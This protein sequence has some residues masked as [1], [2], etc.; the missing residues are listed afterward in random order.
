MT[1]ESMRSETAAA[2]RTHENALAMVREEREYALSEQRALMETM[3]D[4]FALA[5]QA[6]VASARREAR[7]SRAALELW[8]HAGKRHAAMRT[9][10]R[11]L[12]LKRYFSVIL[13]LK[14]GA[15]KTYV[16][17]I[18]VRAGLA[19]RSRFRRR[20]LTTW[21]ATWSTRRAHL[22]H[23][24]LAVGAFRDSSLRISFTTWAAHTRDA[25]E[26]IR[27]RAAA[28]NE[29][30]GNSHRRAWVSWRGSFDRRRKMRAALTGLRFRQ[31]RL[32][33]NSLTLALAELT[34]HRRKMRSVISSIDPR[35]ASAKRVINTL[36]RA[37][38]LW[39]RTVNVTA[40]V[41]HRHKRQGLLEWYS[42]YLSASQQKSAMRSGIAAMR[43]TGLRR[44]YSTWQ[45]HVGEV[46]ARHQRM[47]LALAELHG[48]GLRK[49]WASLMDAFEIRRRAA[50]FLLRMKHG[51]LLRGYNTM[52]VWALQR[53]EDMT[54]LRGALAALDPTRRRMKHTWN[55][56]CA[57][58]ED[59]C[60]MRSAAFG[61]VHSCLRRG[62][63]AWSELGASSK[64]QMDALLRGTSA[65]RNRGMRK[66]LMSWLLFSSE[67]AARTHRMRH[68][69]TQFHASGLS[70]GW[71]TIM[72]A[73]ARRRN[74]KTAMATM[75]LR[76]VRLLCQHMV[77][78]YP[79]A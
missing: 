48:S 73:F 76:K 79:W 8:F 2:A 68:A 55:T 22:V 49:G 5:A 3:Q 52:R 46:L 20:A 17:S 34:S 64:R 70:K 71:R 60:R 24:G 53:S 43:N 65:L 32:A 59:M 15:A 14:D 4:E 6:S 9:M 58:R 18:G 51:E 39:R 57:A 69:L 38:A 56:L 50:G 29:W 1:M 42:L 61:V 21:I 67:S 35:T 12:L 40:R 11:R 30:R 33:F 27:C 23:L 47:R 75:R 41:F 31:V 10:F 78:K 37:G 16:H 25:V 62:L 54:K 72:E 28:L 45:M 13:S 74:M 19:M 66:A 36:R 26:A 44:G 77:W 63:N 7:L